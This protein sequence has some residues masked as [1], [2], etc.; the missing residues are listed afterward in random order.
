MINVAG[1]VIRDAFAVGEALFGIWL[2]SWAIRRR[3]ELDYE[4]DPSEQVLRWSVVVIS[5]VIVGR[6]PGPG[7]LISRAVPLIVGLSFLCW[8]NLGLHLAQLFRQ[9]SGRPRRVVDDGA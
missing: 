6:S 3:Y 9:I 1:A 2:T 4:L 8:P 7:H 5:F